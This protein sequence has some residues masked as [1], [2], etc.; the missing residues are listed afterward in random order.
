MTLAQTAVFTKRAI[1]VFFLL[2]FLGISSFVGFKFYSAYKLAN[3]PPVEIKPDLK[4]G[5]L[6]PIDLPT[7]SNS[8]SNFSYSIDTTTGNLPTF[9][10]LIKVYYIPKTF[11]T[12]LASERAAALAKN[13][14]IDSQPE[15]LSDTK[16]RFSATGKSVTVNLDTENFEYS[17]E[18]SNS[19]TADI[20]DSDDKLI[21]GFQSLLGRIGSGKDTLGGEPYNIELYK[22]NAGKL[23]PATSRVDAEAALI[24]LWPH[25]IDQKKVVTPQT[26]QSLVSAIVDKNSNNV[27]NYMS[28]KFTFWP[29]DVTEFATYPLKT[30]D[31]ALDDLKFGRGSIINIPPTPNVSITKVTLAYFESQTY[32]QYL[33][34]VFLFEGPGFTAYVPAIQDAYVNQ[35][36]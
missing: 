14:G 28:L 9:D 7:S 4:F 12:L 2:I 3:T 30:G 8:G 36:K 32:T 10:K 24:S 29:I 16:Y 33:Q 1:V 26:N 20:L 11:A 25:D 6:P 15:V 23:V 18:A 27:E 21:T 19:A 31:Q 35:S 22:F 13:F 34:P 17:K 5:Q